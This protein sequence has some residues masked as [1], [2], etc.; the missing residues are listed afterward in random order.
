MS[1]VLPMF[2]LHPV[3]TA[4]DRILAVILFRN[5]L[6]DC[7]AGL[8]IRLSFTVETLIGQDGWNA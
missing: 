6:N 1:H 5:L 7:K 3:A 4:S 2:S 8:T